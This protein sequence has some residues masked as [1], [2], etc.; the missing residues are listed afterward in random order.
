MDGCDST[1]VQAFAGRFLDDVSGGMTSV[2]VALGDRL[3]LFRA[4]ADG[5]PATSAELA[6]R[7]GLDERPVREWL[8][9]LLG[10]GYLDVR[11]VGED[12]VFSLSPEHAAVLARDD[13]PFFLGGAAGLVPALAGM[14]EP[15][16]ETF[17]SGGGVPREAYPEALYRTMWRMS[18]SW[19]GT[20]LLP[21]WIPAVDGLAGRLAAG[22][23]VAH[24]GSGAGHALVLI[25]GAY[26]RTRCTGYDPLRLNV[27]R[28]RREAADAGVSGR[29][30]FVH[31]DAAD[32]L[33][34]TGDHALVLALDV[35]HDAP[36]PAAALRA[37]RAALADDGV[38]LLLESAGTERATDN[39]GAPAALLYGASVLYSVPVSLAAKGRAPGMLGLP[40]G[41]LRAL[42]ADAGLRS[43]RQLTPPTPLNALYEIRP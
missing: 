33:P 13:S 31:G 14:L 38:L 29:V 41:A 23:R 8:L 20:L 26:P 15:V 11:H 6:A 10:A 37:V 42:C 17:R 25:A 30:E 36:D 22:A 9:G 3:G 1:A 35:L 32:L 12:P 19:L 18:A 43:V 7:A 16:A 4:L 24:L 27:D 34:G 40:A 39:R 21:Q 2:L 28:A 5:G